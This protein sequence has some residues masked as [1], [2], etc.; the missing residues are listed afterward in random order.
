M[1]LHRLV[2]SYRVDC[3]NQLTNINC[4]N[5]ICICSISYSENPDYDFSFKSGKTLVQLIHVVTLYHARLVL[6]FIG[7]KRLIEIDTFINLTH[8]NEHIDTL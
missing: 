4:K 7:H 8:G 3:N 2:G 5:S 1:F 6:L